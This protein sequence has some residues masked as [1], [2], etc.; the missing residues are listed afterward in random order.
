MGGLWALTVSK[1]QMA[2]SS[3]SSQPS[4]ETGTK[5]GLKSRMW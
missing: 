5:E 2:V 4:T 1:R 3:G